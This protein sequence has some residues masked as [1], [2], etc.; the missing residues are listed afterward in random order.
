[1]EAFTRIGGLV[2]RNYNGQIE[3]SCSKGSVTGDQTSGGLVGRNDSLGSIDVC[4]STAN[5][6]GNTA[7]FND[8][9]EDSVGYGGLAGDNRGIFRNCYATGDIFGYNT[10]GGLMGRNQGGIINSYAAGKVTRTGPSNGGG[11]I[12]YNSGGYC[13]DAFW[14]MN[15]T[16]L[17]STSGNGTGLSTAAMKQKTTFVGSGWNFATIWAI[18]DGLT[19]PELQAFLVVPDPEDDPIVINTVEDLQKIVHDPGYPLHWRY[20]LCGDIDSTATAGW[21][22]EGTSADLLEGFEPIGLYESEDSNEGFTGVFD[23]KGHIITGLTVNRSVENGTGLFAYIGGGGLVLNLSLSN[24][25]VRGNDWTGGLAG[26][27]GGLV[28]D[29]SSEGTVA[30]SSDTGGLIGFN[31]VE[32]RNCWSAGLVSGYWHVGGLVGDST[33]LVTHCWSTSKVEGR[34]RAGGLIGRNNDGLVEY[35]SA[36]GDVSGPSTVGGLAGRNEYNGLVKCCHA[37]GM[38]VGE[39]Q[40]YSDDGFRSVAAAGLVADNRGDVTECFATG[41]VSGYETIG[42][43]LGRNEGIVTN[44]YATGSVT[45]YGPQNAGG[46]VGYLP[47]GQIRYCYAVGHINA[48]GYRGGL[49]GLGSPCYFSF[50]DVNTT[51]LTTSPGGGTGL[52]TAQMMHRETYVDAGWDFTSVWKINDGSSYPVLRI[53]FNPEAPDNAVA[54]WLLWE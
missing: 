40:P 21:N 27:S 12:G 15:A 34:F 14:D 10:V 23:G 28:I 42:G 25:F 6:Y 50:W 16:G 35:C 29:C 11:L 54:D 24:V 3:F 2:G 47:S 37:S 19:Y 32:M 33:Q 38:V 9:G 18:N 43:L 17:S 41:N 44:S 5:V 4:Y 30:G 52:P 22:D 49:V 46:L 1:M 20:V 51:G 13:T 36:S 39:T 26:V 8:D 7:A 53:V 48:T 45:K 31:A